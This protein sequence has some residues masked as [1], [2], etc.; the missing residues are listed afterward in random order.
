M[1]ETS[2]RSQPRK[3]TGKKTATRSTTAA[4]RART[5][6]RSAAKTA[7]TTTKRS[8]TKAARSAR[9][10]A[11]STPSAVT[12]VPA[13]VAGVLGTAGRQ[14]VD[15]ASMPV[16][17]ARRVLDQRGGLPVYVGAGALAAVGAIGW[18][19][20]AGVGAGYAALRRWGSQLPEPLRSLTGS[21]P[22]AR[23]R[24]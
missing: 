22:P 4:G 10:T 20:A 2:K 13:N 3:S 1:A 23:G 24:S 15:L 11:A 12:G 14:A 8:T 18:P 21:R 16:T 19:V 17:A 6:S 5:T 7:S 9:S